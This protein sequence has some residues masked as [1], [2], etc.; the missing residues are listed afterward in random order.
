MSAL[1]ER[2]NRLL[3]LPSRTSSEPNARPLQH[4]RLNFEPQAVNIA[5]PPFSCLSGQPRTA[6]QAPRRPVGPRDNRAAGRPERRSQPV[7]QRVQHPPGNYHVGQTL[8]E[9]SPWYCEP[10]PGRR[11]RGTRPGARPNVGHQP[12][13]AIGLSRFLQHRVNACKAASRDTSKP[14]AGSSPPL[15]AIHPQGLLGLGES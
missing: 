12:Q 15:K 13:S 10:R 2:S 7:I 8:L 11:R 3:R 1:E 6:R 14:Y 9:P 4:W 5:T